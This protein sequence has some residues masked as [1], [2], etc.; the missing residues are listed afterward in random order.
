ME[1][2]RTVIALLALFERP[3]TAAERHEATPTAT[4][5]MVW[6]SSGGHRHNFGHVSL[7]RAMRVGGVTESPG[8]L[9]ASKARVHF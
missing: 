1:G 3:V 9:G 4:L 7:D 5:E 2:N 8:S 6:Y